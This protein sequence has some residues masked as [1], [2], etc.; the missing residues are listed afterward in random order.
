MKKAG[1]EQVEDLL[2]L[3]EKDKDA[4]AER[5]KISRK[6]IDKWQEHADLM[7]ITGVGPEYAE[8][9]NMVGIDSVKELAQRNP[10]NTVTRIQ[11]MKKEKPNVI[12]RIPSVDSLKKWIA[13]SKTLRFG[14]HGL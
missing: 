13:D 7:R 8:A 3:S 10:E 2:P 5:L 12:R 14:F 6:L 4:L 1:Y 11:E 9:L